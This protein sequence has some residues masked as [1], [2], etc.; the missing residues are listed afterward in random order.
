MCGVLLDGGEVKVEEVWELGEV[1]GVVPALEKGEDVG[2]E[3]LALW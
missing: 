1:G 3:V 2:V